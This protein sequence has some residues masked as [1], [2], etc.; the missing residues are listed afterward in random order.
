MKVKLANPEHA[1]GMIDPVT[2]TSPF[3]VIDVATD[4]TKTKRVVPIADVPENIHWVRRTRASGH[5]DA[6][7]WLHDGEGFTR[8]LANG[9]TVREVAPAATTPVGNEPIAPLTTRA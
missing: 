2:R 6:E 1:E 9:K 8:H 3:V 5:H 7:L 4:G